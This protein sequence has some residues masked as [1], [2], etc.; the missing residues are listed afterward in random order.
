MVSYDFE[1]GSQNYEIKIQNFDFQT[2][3][4]ILPCATK[5]IPLATPFQIS[6]S[7]LSAEVKKQTHASYDIA[8]P[9]TDKLMVKYDFI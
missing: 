5:N 4:Y 6:A 1:M 8:V 3:T 7:F 9:A 2:L